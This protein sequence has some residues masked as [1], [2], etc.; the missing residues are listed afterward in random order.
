MDTAASNPVPWLRVGAGESPQ[1]GGCVMQ[2]ID[3]IDRGGWT[4]EPRCVYHLLRELAI[5]VNDDLSDA[6][7][8][9]LLDL[10]PR[11]MGT[12]MIPDEYGVVYDQ[13]LDDRLNEVIAYFSET[14]THSFHGDEYLLGLLTATLDEYDRYTGRPA[15]EEKVD[16]SAVCE[17]MRA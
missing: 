16:F 1:D 4:D 15:V 17:V 10:V 7:R 5:S 14:Q 12:S 9:K 6:G 2:V 11:L 8:Q 13:D 3:W